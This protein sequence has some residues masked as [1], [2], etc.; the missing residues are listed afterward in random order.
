MRNFKWA[1]LSVALVAGYAS[2][3]DAGNTTS[4]DDTNFFSGIT[5]GAGYA[6][7]SNIHGN[8]LNGYSI[9]SRGYIVPSLRDYLFTDFRWSHT[10]DDI[11]YGSDK[12]GNLQTTTADLERY[13][14]ALG[15]GYPFQATQSI[16]IKPYLTAGWAWDSIEVES[17]NDHAHA[18][19]DGMVG[20][21]G[22]ETQFGQHVVTNLGYSEQFSGELKADQFM[23]DVGYRFK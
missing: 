13:Q 11:A 5:L 9:F 15:V 20:A 3:A 14:A 4:S 18:H 19:D 8:T 16:K 23:L 10:T 12:H 1:I 2:A 22:I 7:D 6:Q 21:L 17:H